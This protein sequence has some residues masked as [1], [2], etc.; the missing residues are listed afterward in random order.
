[1]NIAVLIPGAWFS[2]AFFDRWNV[3]VNEIKYQKHNLLIHRQEGANVYHIRNSLLLGN[4]LAGQFQHPFVGP[5]MNFDYDYILMVDSDMIFTYQDMMNLIDQEKDI[6][7]GIARIGDGLHWNASRWDIHG[8]L[9]TGLLPFYTDEDL[10]KETFE[11]DVVG[12]AFMVIK[13]G[14]FEKIAY[15][16]F[17]AH[18]YNLNGCTIESGEDIGFCFKARDA[19]FKV[20]V[21]PR[22]KIGHEKRRILT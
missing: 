15:P 1:M 7:S 17:V 18:R 6:I 8:L 12:T 3:F 13:R 9:N 4:A 16:W 11:T 20:W 10:P 21:D 14:V 2:G 5:P 19:G 22:V